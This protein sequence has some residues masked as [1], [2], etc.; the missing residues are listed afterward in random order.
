[1]NIEWDRGTV[2]L[3]AL[4]EGLLPGELPGLSWDPRVGAWR[5]LGHRWPELRALLLARGLEPP[6]LLR[7][8]GPPA[9]AWAPLGLRPYQEAALDAWEVAGRR[10]LVVLPTG[11][12][13]TRVA[14]AAGARC[15]SAMLVLV[16]TRALMSQWRKEL[17]GV[18]RTAIGAL[19]DGEKTLEPITVATFESAWRH[20]PRL[21]DRFGLL[22]VDEAHHF[23][24]GARDEALELSL[25]PF[26]IGLTATPP[27]RP[28]AALRLVDLIGPTVFSL[29]IDD[30]AGTWLAE[31]EHFVL[32]LPLSPGERRDHACDRATFR[33]FAGPF[34][35]EHPDAEWKDLLRAAR[36][37]AE[38][39]RAVAAWRRAER[40]LNYTRAK[41]E[42]LG[43]LLQRHRG[44][45]TLVFV[46][47][48]PTAHRVAREHLV[49]PITAQV[50]RAE[51][52]WALRAFAA[53]ELRGLVSP[54]VLDEGIDVPAAE[55]AIVLGGSGERQ[56]TQRVGRVLRPAEGKTALL[57]EL[58]AAGTPE[59]HRARER[60]R[61]LRGA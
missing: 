30:L 33:A 11:S 26:R 55:V 37:S 61:G 36:G 38:G 9:E 42:V 35:Q 29:G 8:L 13:K 39:R 19:G 48:V 14:L 5:A 27:D 50:G 44:Q 53:G 54:R 15:G 7:A 17:A 3:E 10:G 49:M 12:G 21:G 16:P 28:A 45:R 57:Y 47:D 6:E 46:G 34:R 59:V 24:S 1:M 41:A 20:M 4:P 56:H 2:R 43:R 31:L 51:R 60:R 25:A 22:V 58:V 52:T 18:V 40:L 32:S 23:G